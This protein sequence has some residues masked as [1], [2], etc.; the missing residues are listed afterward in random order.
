VMDGERRPVPAFL[1][2][3]VDP[4]PPIEPVVSVAAAPE[5]PTT[6]SPLGRVVGARSGDKGGNANVGVWTRTDEGY[7]WLEHFL[8]AQRFRE[9]VPE[10]ADLVIDR[11]EL[12]NLRALNFVVHGWLG[13]GVA[14]STRLDP[15]AKGFGE[16]LRAKC[17]EIP[18][19]L[20]EG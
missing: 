4:E 17:V 9:L 1:R 3:S 18:D 6:R 19:V 16:Y 7:A 20:L 2:A 11:H 5:G 12:P 13:R 15:Q 14:A 8:T 10:A